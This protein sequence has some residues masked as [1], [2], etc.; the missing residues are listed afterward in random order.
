M[1]QWREALVLTTAILIVVIATLEIS[2]DKYTG[3]I[4]ID[5]FNEEDIKPQLPM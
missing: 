5:G 1:N 2:K 3:V 4:E